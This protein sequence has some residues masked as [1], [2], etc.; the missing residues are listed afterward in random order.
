MEPPNTYTY[1]QS[2]LPQMTD[3]IQSEISEIG[4]LVAT[5]TMKY[6]HH[7]TALIEIAKACVDWL[8]NTESEIYK[9]RILSDGGEPEL[10]PKKVSFTDLPTLEK[11]L[12][13]STGAMST[14]AINMLATFLGC[15]FDQAAI[16]VS[17][18]VDARIEAIPPQKVEE[19]VAEMAKS[20]REHPDKSFLQIQF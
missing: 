14:V 3:E 10:L 20:L 13:I 6:Q 5:L 1:R 12:I 2:E 15:T 18:E 4:C 17:K 8:N 7:P 11:Q 9:I 19:L 16:H